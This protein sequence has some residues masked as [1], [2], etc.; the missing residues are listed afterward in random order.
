MLIMSRCHFLSCFLLHLDEL[1]DAIVHLFDSV[2]FGETHTPLV[3][4]VVDATLSLSVLAAGSTHLQ[5]V[6]AS[7]LI[8]LSLVGGQLGYLDVHGGT[9]SCSQVGWAESEET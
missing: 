2:E 9:D 1:G 6:F 7:N 5:V 3:G 4:D 8:E